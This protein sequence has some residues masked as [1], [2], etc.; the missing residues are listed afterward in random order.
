MRVP[1]YMQIYSNFGCEWIKGYTTSGKAAKIRKF[2]QPTRRLQVTLSWYDTSCLHEP[3][4]SFLFSA[5]SKDYFCVFLYS[6]VL[7]CVHHTSVKYQLHQ[8]LSCSIIAFPSKHQDTPWE[9]SDPSAKEAL[10]RIDCRLLCT[11]FCYFNFIHSICLI[12]IKSSKS[13][14]FYSHRHDI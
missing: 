14:V 6:A 7:I 3:S 10:R 13:H 1:D 8:L 2:W 4:C 5:P 11:K 9:K 12:Y